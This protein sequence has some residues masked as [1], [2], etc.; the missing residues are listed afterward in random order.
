MSADTQYI[1]ASSKSWHREK[2]E[3]LSASVPGDWTYVSTKE[4]LLETVDICSPRYIFFLHWSWL[5]PKE[6]WATHE[7]ICFHMTDVPY[8]RGGSPLQ[9]LISQG[10]KETKIAALQMVEEL[11]A[12]PVYLKRTMSLAGRA[13]EIYLRAGDI[14]YEMIL[15]IISK[16][17]KPVA[18]YGEVTLFKRRNPEQSELP[19]VG[20]VESIYDH[21]RMLDAPT[22][23]LAF[24]VHG[25][26]HIEFTHAQLDKDEVSA[27]VK[28]RRKD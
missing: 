23:P 10:K 5:V 24:V 12:G 18:Q 26:F 27:R 21:I 17:P 8:G 4:E 28:I 1:I 15:S 25:D 16:T 11:D 3:A 7:S 9:N 6:I 20:G 19:A 22:Y 13:E 2:Y 14:C